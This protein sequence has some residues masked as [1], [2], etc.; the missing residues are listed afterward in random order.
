MLDD[1]RERMRRAARAARRIVDEDALDAYL[2]VVGPELERTRAE[3]RTLA[4]TAKLAAAERDEY[5]AAIVRVRALHTQG[6]MPD[7]CKEC[8][9]VPAADCPT[10]RALD[11]PQAL[12][13]AAVAPTA[14]VTVTGG[15]RKSQEG[16]A[17]MYAL[18]RTTPEGDEKQGSPVRRTRDAATY[19]ALVLTDN[20]NTPKAEAQRFAALLDRTPVGDSVRHESGYVFRIERLAA[21]DTPTEGAPDGR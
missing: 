2:S 9:H 18:V 10:L 5:K 11:T 14:K 8:N 7:M 3:A 20:L 4:H 16:S 21:L 13:D 6:V 12:P 17:V 19:A 1:L 15:S